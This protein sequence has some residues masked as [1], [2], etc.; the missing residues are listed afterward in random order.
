MALAGHT[1][2]VTGAS[3]GI[4]AAVARALSGAGV[5]VAVTSRGGEDLELAA[6][7]C[8][9]VAVPADVSSEPEVER[10]ATAV[11]RELDAP[12]DIVVNNAGVFS[13]AP[14]HVTSPET[15][16]RHLE[17]NLLG[18]FLVTR[19][20]LGEMLDRGSGDLL[21]M[22]S[23]A[24]REPLPGNAA[25]SASKYG[26]RG[27]HEVLDVE[28][29]GTGVRSLLLEPGAV[30]TSAWDPLADRLGSDL[31]ARDAMLAPRDVASAALELL[32]SGPD[33]GRERTLLP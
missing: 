9:G 13:L 18:A 15:F 29:E 20:F 2:L 21:H 31:P 24:G 14:A 16:R 22:G 10:M 33:Q 27:L 17:V 5:R 11:R 4:G 28:L 8:D 26:L 6:R 25:Y 3:R 7:A 1:A 23:V 19:A 30:D 32:R 12:P